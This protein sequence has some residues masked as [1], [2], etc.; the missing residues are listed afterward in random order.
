[1]G[2]LMGAAGLDRIDE[3]RRALRHAWRGLAKSPWFTAVAVITLGLGIGVNTAIFSVIHAVLIAPLPYD[4]AGRL[5]LIRHSAPLAGQTDV[6]VSI[7]ELYDYRERLNSFE[8]LVEF[9]QMDFDLLRRGDP[10]RVATGVVSHNFF[11]VLSILPLHGR[12]FVEADD[13]AGAEA[14]LVL[15][16]AYWQSRF[17]G[18]PGVIGQVLEMNDR[19]HTVIGVLPPVALYPNEVDVFMPTSACPFRAAG[20]R[21]MA[22]NRRAFSMLRVFGKLKHG[23]APETAAAEVASVGRDF[24]REFPTIY[25]PEGGF[26][27]E[28]R[29]VQEALTQ[30]ARP[31]L[32]VLVGITGLVLLLACAN[33]GNLTLART[34]ERAHERATRA[35]LGAGRLSLLAQPLAESTLIALAGAFVGLSFA[36][37]TLGLIA[38]FVGRFTSRAGEIGIAWPVLAFTVG[39]ALLAGLLL[40][41]LPALGARVDLAGALKTGSKGAG[42]TPRR[43][44][45]H[46][47]V[48]GQVTVSVVLL[49][50]AGLLLLSVARLQS[51]DT[52][53][54]V[55]RVLSA[56]IFANFSKYG[57]P[58]SRDRLY[59]NVLERLEALPGVAAAAVTNA[60]PLSDMRHG[61]TRLQVEGRSDELAPMVDVRIASPGYFD[62]LGIPLLRGRAFATSDTESTERVAVINEA[63]ARQWGNR[64][65]LGARVSADGGRTWYRVVGVVGD[66]RHFGLDVEAVAQAYVALAQANGNL[67]GRIL[68][69]TV[70]NPEA[71]MSTIRS[72]IQEVDPNMPIERMQTLDT[73]RAAHLATPRLTALLLS[74]FAGLALCIT[75]TGLAG[76]IATSIAQRTRE[77]GLR[78]AIGASARGVLAMVLEQALKLIGLGLVIGIP[79][80]VVFGFALQSFLFQTAPADPLMLAGVAVALAAAGA[81]GCVGPAVRASRID[82]ITALR[83]E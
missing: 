77:I 52:G 60:V 39:I 50:A 15:G 78:I 36:W 45:Q 2:L 63:G 35:A 21:E 16:H 62:A 41:V 55:D 46:T 56:E 47:L 76:V 65:P 68:A 5:V 80:A 58:E 70:G 49:A 64:D 61:Q 37:G 74:I 13:R 66:V 28:T 57:T 34:L 6:G 31:M 25:R 8:G 51:V 83:A 19:P 42:G 33:V 12:T 22:S 20:E 11:D 3:A 44:L 26:R 7:R 38:T 71:A 9:H 81:L 4:D 14:V 75:V 30:N 27:A 73:L 59:R 10:D 23:V 82:P 67:Q 43:R 72:A 54:R 1:M 40:G 17:G 29:A 69:R 18:D 24:A 79:L 32:L 48:A 53:Y